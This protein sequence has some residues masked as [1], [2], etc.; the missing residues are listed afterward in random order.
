MSIVIIIAT[1]SGV[2]LVLGAAVSLPRALAEF[3]LACIP[4]ISA[5]AELRTAVSALRPAAKQ[6]R[7]R[8]HKPVVITHRRGRSRAWPRD[9]LASLAG[10]QPRPRARQDELLR[11]ATE[12][13]PVLRAAAPTWLWA[14]WHPPASDDCRPCHRSAR[15]LRHLGACIVLGAAGSRTRRNFP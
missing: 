1:I 13:R 8:P 14:T 2:V 9:P 11:L 12:P 7:P 4:V 5:I 6:R 10:S 3:I 15:P